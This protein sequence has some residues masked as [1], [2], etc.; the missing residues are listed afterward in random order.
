M[1]HQGNDRVHQD[2]HLFQDQDQGKDQ[3]SGILK[4]FN[5]YTE[6][7]AK[8]EIN[9]V[10]YQVSASFVIAILLKKLKNSCN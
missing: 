10:V 5:H 1:L 8:W 9:T 4:E 7:S 2:S 3:K 6:E